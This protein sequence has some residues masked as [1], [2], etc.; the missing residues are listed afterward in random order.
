MEVIRARSLA[1]IAQ[2]VSFVKIAEAIKLQNENEEN[3]KA[4]DKRS[5]YPKEFIRFNVK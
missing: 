1:E 5:A 4:D 3:I 2:I